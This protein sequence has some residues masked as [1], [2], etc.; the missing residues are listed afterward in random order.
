VQQ[1][2]IVN[3]LPVVDIVGTANSY[4]ICEADATGVNDG[5]EVFD[6]TS[7]TS[8]LLEGNSTVPASTYSVA[9]Y[10]GPGA[11]NPIATPSAYTNTSNP[12]T[13]FVVV[14]NTITGCTS[15]VGNFEIIVN[16]KPDLF[17]L[18]AFETCDNIDGVNDGM[19]LYQNN[20]LG[21][22]DYIDEILGTTQ[23]PADYTVSFYTSQADAVAGLPATAIQD[24]VN[25]Q[26]MTGT[27]WIRVTNNATGCYQ[28]SSFDVVVEI[29]AEPLITSNTG[30]NIACVDFPGTAVN[31]NLILDSNVS[32]TDYTF[33]WYAGGV[34]IANENS[35]T[36][37]ITEMDADQIVYSVIAISTS[38][39]ACP[40]EEVSF[41]VVRSGQAAN[42][43]Y[44][45]SNAFSEMQTIT[46]TNEG[47]GIYHYSLDDGPILDNGGIFTNVTLGVHT[48]YI[49]DVRDP[50][51]YS[52]GV[53]SITG[54]Q[55]IDYPHYFTPNGDGIHDSWNIV[56]LGEQPNAKIYIF[57]RHGKLLK[58]ISPTSN[59]WDGTYNGQLMPGDDYWFTVDYIE[60]TQNKQFRA[61]FALKR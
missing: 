3:P 59:G 25:Y 13:I 7:L 9:F 18:A 50:D 42:A 11:T 43:T 56:G 28:T 29:I 40:S 53:V 21:L 10:A 49:W 24:L 6:L 46:V 2:Y 1:G 48:I 15:D 16:P 44:T 47:Y 60:Q 26:V 20:P 27:Y 32:N 54:V 57:D 58:Q 5:F 37:A 45:V 4:Q 22:A 39:L 34:L 12:Q 31:N 52:C 36:L 8:D 23:S 35:A 14:T 17:P 38:S 51:G 19:A 30:S 41:T 61:H 33:E 55:I